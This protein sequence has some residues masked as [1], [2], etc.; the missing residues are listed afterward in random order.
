MSSTRTIPATSGRLPGDS[1]L[2][3][4]AGSRVSTESDSAGTPVPSSSPW[5]GYLEIR[6]NGGSVSRRILSES[7][8]V[9]GRVPG[10][11]LLLDHHTVSRR[12]A[13]MFCDP[14]GRWW[15][16][17][18]GSTNGTLVNDEPVTEKV[19]QPS[20]KIAIGDFMVSFFLEPKVETRS[21]RGAIALD[22][23]KPTAIRTLMDFDPPRI[24]AEHLRNLMEFS[25][26]LISVEDPQERLA[27]LCHLMIG[28]EFRASLA[29]AL[30]IRAGTPTMLSRP[31]RPS[32]H[33]AD[34]NPYISRRV[35]GK[36]QETREPVL[37]GNLASPGPGGPPSVELTMSRDVMALWVVACPLALQ[38]DEMD[39]LYVTLPPDL[40]SVE[41][42][43]LIALAAEVY[44]QSESAWT[45]RRHAQAHAAIERELD[46]ARQIQ[47]GL[48]PKKHD[49]PGFDVAIAFEP[50]KWVGGDY[51]DVV[52]MPDGR[53]LFAV[54]DVCG[55]GLQAALVTSS[56]HTMVRAT[57]DGGRSLPEL[58]ER[59]NK[60][61]CEWLPAHSFVTMVAIAVDP[62]TGET[63]CVNAGHPPPIAV[64]SSGALRFLQSAVNPALGV[65]ITTMESQRGTLAAGDVLLLYT[66]G[67]TELRNTSKD[68]LGQERLG[69]GFLR[70]CMKDGPRGVSAISVGLRQ[71]LESFRGDQLPE[72][73]RAFLLVRRR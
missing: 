33:Q 47:R 43:S 12:H 32:S 19:L 66:D 61:L 49:F 5:K 51:V 36:L 4:T 18:L 35:L 57:T 42:L 25:R 31:F 16:R 55:K 22:D 1:A 34:G 38:D 37:A 2:T 20:D 6:L 40:G 52:P 27:Q 23:D 8:V 15:I 46:T 39:V 58:M 9:I 73:D 71:L 45:A 72:D 59:V 54:A 28:K 26:R 67:L 10:V 44:Q 14:F 53:M 48:V 21:P 65:A 11:Q 13:E 56:V 7:H 62:V 63:E 24:A 64:S 70:I 29:V 3:P 60:H 17:D 41:W 68:M 30:R 50:C 69:E